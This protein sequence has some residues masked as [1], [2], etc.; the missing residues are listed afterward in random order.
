MLDW[1][2]GTVDYLVCLVV[3]KNDICGAHLPL[4]CPNAGLIR[5]SYSMTL[6]YVTHALA[7]SELSSHSLLHHRYPFMERKREYMMITTRVPPDI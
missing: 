4:C 2:S 1:G 5:V 6:H 3:P 7:Y